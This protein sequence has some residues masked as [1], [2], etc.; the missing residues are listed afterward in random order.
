[1]IPKSSCP[2]CKIVLWDN[3]PPFQPEEK[4]YAI[5][6]YCG[7]VSRFNN[8]LIL[9]KPKKIPYDV[10]LK[11]NLAKLA[12]SAKISLEQIVKNEL[13]KSGHIKSH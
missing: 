11:S 9:I 10:R 5:C 6:I 13:I 4:D 1:M 7:E 12:I 8:Q 2:Y 3:N